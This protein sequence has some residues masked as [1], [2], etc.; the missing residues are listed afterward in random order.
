MSGC[1]ANYIE[2]P[3]A[4]FNKHLILNWIL[5]KSILTDCLCLL[6]DKMSCSA[7]MHTQ[8]SRNT[9]PFVYSLIKK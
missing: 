6:A 9:S 2:I 8:E 5:C 4:K 7:Q 1:T 3:K